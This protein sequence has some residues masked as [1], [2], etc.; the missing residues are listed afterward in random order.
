MSFRLPAGLAR[1][2]G[3]MALALPLSGCLGLDTALRG[4]PGN[5][6]GERALLREEPSLLVASL[7]RPAG[8]GR[9][10]PFFTSDRGQGLSFAL[11]G[12]APPSDSGFVSRLASWET[13]QWT[14]RKIDRLVTTGAAEA[15]ATAASGRDVLI[16]VHGY[17]ETFETAASGAAT[18]ADAIG[19]RGRAALF[20]W[21][22]GGRLIAYAYDRES[23]LWSRDGFVETLRALGANP[24]VG[25]VHIVAHSMGAF[26]TLETLRQL[27][28]G[29]GE[30]SFAKLGAVVLASPDVD[31]DQFES[32]VKRQ[33][34]LAGHITVISATN[35]RALAVSARLAGGVA[36]AGASERGR[37]EA[38]GV[39]VADASD[40]GWGVLRHDLFLSNDEVRAVISRAIA[41]AR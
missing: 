16:Y 19:F 32:A 8:N 26:L 29:A 33:A 35:D 24:A 4:S 27:A 18:L 10:A 7:R 17:N 15:F 12:L 5:P 31:I 20:A 39:R 28:T 41:R 22:S 36:R 25:K 37:L 6:M 1:A 14:T 3:L 34:G 38:L 23:A 21:P 2:L 13:D 30:A 11:T 40:I 9:A